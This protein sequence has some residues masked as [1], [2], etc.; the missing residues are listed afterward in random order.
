MTKAPRLF[1]AVPQVP[2][3]PYRAPD[4]S[5]N[6]IGLSNPIVRECTRMQIVKQPVTLESF[7]YQKALKMLL[8]SDQLWLH[9]CSS[10]YFVI[11]FFY[12]IILLLHKTSC[13]WT[14][15]LWYQRER[16]TKHTDR[17]LGRTK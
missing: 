8:L 15:N 7:D 17:R 4:R 11:T 12:Y 9:I 16:S 13:A 10:S 3:T 5:L 14:K 1:G 6:R 2:D